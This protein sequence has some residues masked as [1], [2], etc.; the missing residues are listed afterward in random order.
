MSY[1]AD[2]T[3]AAAGTLSLVMD[4]DLARA[5]ERTGATQAEL[6]LIDPREHSKDQ[7][8]K[9]F[10]LCSEISEWSGHGNTDLIF[11]GWVSPQEA[12]YELTDRFC[13]LEGL[14]RFS[15]ADV[16]MEICR[17]F[18][19]YLVDF[20]LSHDVPTRQPLGKLAEDADQYIYACMLHRKCSLCGKPADIHHVDAIQMGH[21]RDKVNHVGRRAIALCRGHHDEAHKRGV[22]TFFDLHHLPRGIKLSPYLC[23]QLGLK[24]N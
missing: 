22:K 5:I 14:Q 23:A 13:A 1:R 18:I 4:E 12:R 11:W 21:D 19:T 8:G 17:E 9:V 15:M 2:I 6:R 24:R 16:D 10:A 20:C 3:A 7:H